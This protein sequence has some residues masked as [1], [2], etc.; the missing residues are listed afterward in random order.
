MLSHDRR[1]LP[2]YSFGLGDRTGLQGIALLRA[3]DAA[4]ALYP[5]VPFCPVWNKSNR[6]HKT[7]GSTPD[8]ARAAADAAVKQYGW[9]GPYFCDADHIC[10]ANVDPF[11]P[12]C[13]FFT[14]DVTSY[15]GKRESKPEDVAKF[16]ADNAELAAQGISVRGIDRPLT[17]TRTELEH[18]TALYMPTSEAA[19]DI[20][21]HILAGREGKPFVVEVSMDEFPTPQTPAQIYFIMLALHG[22]PLQTFAPKFSGRFNKGVDYV[23]DA[24]QFGREFEEDALVLAHCA[25]EFGLPAGLKLSVHSGSDKFSIYPPIG[26]ALLKTGLGLHIKTAGT[27]WLEEIIGLSLSGDAAAVEV[28]RDI[29]LWAMKRV[30]ELCGPY[31]NVIDIDHSRLPSEAE[32]RKYTGQDFA[33]AITHDPTNPKF[34]P[35]LRQMTHLGYKAVKEMGTRFYDAIERNRAIVEKCVTFNILERHLKPLLSNM[36]PKPAAALKGYKFWFIT[37]TQSLYGEEVIKQVARDSRTIVDALNAD[38]AVVGQ[39]VFKDAVIDSAAITAVLMAA[40]ADP[41]CAGVIGWMHTFSPSKMWI[42]GLTKLQKPYLHFNTQFFRDIPWGS[43]DMDYMNLHQS[44]HGDREH[45]FIGARLRM[46]RKVIAGHWQDAKIRA[47]IGHWMRS[48]IGAAESRKLRVVRFGD[49][50]RDVAVTEGDKVEAEIKFGWSVNGHGIGDLIAVVDKVTEKEIDAKMAEYQAVYDNNT[51]KVESVRYQARMQVALEKFLAEGGFAAFTD[52]FQD[53]QQLRQLPG[54]AAQDLMR[55]GY[56]FGAEGDW[57]L[58]A[59]ARV[60]KVMG[61]GMPGGT[62]FMEDYS[63]HMDPANEGILGAHMLEVDPSL[64]ADRPRVEVHQ[65]GIGGKEDPARLC[66]NTGPGKAI[67]ATIVDMGDRFRVIVND[68]EACAPFED[69]PKLP[70]ARVMWKPMP[71]LSTSAEAWIMAG[72]AHHTVLS[73]QLDAE[74]IRDWC[75]IMGVEFVHIGKNTD[76]AQLQAELMCNDVVWRHK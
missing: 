6:A 69:M 76:L 29:C 67:V 58:A 30:D 47:R 37:G 51:N 42:S 63:Y 39:I 50:M 13:D 19:S 5:S 20:Y 54:L 12:H 56:G 60:M 32:L 52:T 18:L 57:K 28:V 53:L 73:Y 59:L 43:I 34:N 11:I 45:G 7:V 25:H 35:S 70:V 36:V 62:A 1:P 75:N 2:K 49:N 16:V 26:R 48:A 9:K 10:M 23:G 17:M 14:I 24:E 41:D 3:L 72:G 40:N 21:K 66:F 44:A 8:K 38:P 46:A 15:I 74:H 31:S 22:V 4:E 65:L 55:K 27:T 33:D 61:T 68:V 71:D 64:A